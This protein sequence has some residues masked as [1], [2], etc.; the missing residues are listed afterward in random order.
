M[1]QQIFFTINRDWTSS[2]LDHLMTV[3]SSWS[4]WLPIAIVAAVLMALWGGWHGR[5]FLLVALIALGVSDGLVVNPI[6]HL[7]GRPRPFQSLEGVRTLDLARARPRLLA[8]GRPLR[9]KFSNAKSQRDR[10]NS[11]PSGH[12]ANTF[13]LATVI[14][15]FYRRRGWL[16]LPIAALVAYSRMYI[17]VHWP[18]DVLV[19]MFIGLGIGLLV[20]AVCEWLWTRWGPKWAPQFAAHHPSLIQQ[21]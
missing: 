19:G 14:A 11:F 21:P 7:V 12:A 1:E 13:T 17:G 3:V 10:G 6:K 20:T 5:A 15:V 8:V 18:L 2:A 16:A 9:V 4:F